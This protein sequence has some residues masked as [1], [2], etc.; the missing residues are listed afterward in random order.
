LIVFRLFAFVCSDKNVVMRS[1]IANK[2]QC[3]SVTARVKRLLVRSVGFNGL[4]ALC[5]ALGVA[6]DCGGTTKVS[7]E[8]LAAALDRFQIVLS[9]EELDAV[10]S[11]YDRL[12]NGTIDPV[13]FTAALRA[14]GINAA[15]RTLMERAWGTLSKDPNGA[16]D[17]KQLNKAFVASAHPDVVCGNRSEAQV[18]EEFQSAFNLETNPTGCV[19]PQEFEQYYSAVSA[20]VEEEETFAALMRGCWSIAGADAYFTATL[21]MTSGSKNKSFYAIQSIQVKGEITE[22]M[23]RKGALARVVGKHRDALLAARLGF[24]G[25]SRLLRARDVGQ[26]GYLCQEDFTD[27]LWQNRLYVEDTSL[28]S[29][30]DTNNDNTI[31]VTLYMHM[32]LPEIPPARRCVLERLWAKLPTDAHDKVD[33]SA[34]HKRFRAPDGNALNLFLDAW[35]KRVVPSGRVG[36]QELVEWYAPLSHRTPMDAVFEQTVLAEWA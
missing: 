34:I 2:N 27:A 7:K 32:V 3:A 10:W 14:N 30:L 33:I 9:Q 24:R 8:D 6:Q 21:A 25:L 36:F 15:R 16:V 18:K 28:L 26:V 35:D 5:R 17:I 31:D 11:E 29:L 4:R 13:D 12:G 23:Q 19:T 22:A 20:T 1:A